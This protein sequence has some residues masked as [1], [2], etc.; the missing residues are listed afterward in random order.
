MNLQSDKYEPALTKLLNELME[1]D[2]KISIHYV[3]Y[4][5]K[6]FT[7][8]M[9]LTKKRIERIKNDLSIYKLKIEI[10]L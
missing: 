6:H 9:K 4:E 8:P 7:V 10:E 1:W 5:P 2:A 3:D